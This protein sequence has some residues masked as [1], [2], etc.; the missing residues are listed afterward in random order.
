ML[1]SPT[2]MNFLPTLIWHIG[3][4]VYFLGV[5]AKSRPTRFFTGWMVG[6]TLIILSHFAARVIYAPLSGYVYWI[7]GIGS[8]LLA[9]TFELQFAYHFLCTPWP[10]EARAV[11][12]VSAA[13]TVGMVAGML[14][15]VASL[16]HQAVYNFTQFLYGLYR[17]NSQD[18]F[19]SAAIFDIV[20]PIGHLWAVIVLLRKTLYLTAP[21]PGQP[22]WRRLWRGLWRPQTKEARSARTLTCLVATAPLTAVVEILEAHYLLPPASFALLYMLLVFTI[23][24]V[25]VDNAPERSA[26][27]VRITGISLLTVLLTIGLLSPRLLAQERE[28]YTQTQ[29]A[30]LAHV[31]TLIE[32]GQ[33]LAGRV[34]T[35]VAYVA[36]RPA[37]GGIFATDYR[38][39]FSREPALDA[40]A[41]A[42]QD[43]AMKTGLEQGL[44]NAQTLVLT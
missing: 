9:V 6:L 11:L 25:Y 42:Q 28:T 44:F 35:E 27:M 1:I 5:R 33:V 31:K 4:L 10:R 29:R 39:L 21:Q 3:A 22:W 8:A 34:P 41:L 23:V 13:V 17:L 15:E 40:Q 26:F 7:G 38:V 19:T 20:H 18:I 16:P 30:E 32:T 36:A 14:A 43:A 37:G 24:L 12:L 2:A